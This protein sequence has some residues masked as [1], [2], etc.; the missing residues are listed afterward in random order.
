MPTEAI[1]VP[2]L[3]EEGAIG[4]FLVELASHAVGRRV[5]LLDSGSRDGTVAEAQCQARECGLDL[6]VVDCPPG[7]AE[8]ILFGVE[9]VPEQHVAVID[10]DGQH[11][12]AVLDALFQDLSDGVDVAVGSRLVAGASVARNWPRYRQMASTI[13]LNLVR[14]AVRCHQI[15][16]PLSGCFAL[17]RQAWQK[18]AKRF[19]TGGYK[20]LLDFLAASRDLRVTERPLQFRARHTGDSKLAFAVL[21]ELLVSVARGVFRATV[22]R[23]WI[24]FVGVGALGTASDILLTG[25]VYSLL[26]DAPFALACVASMLAYIGLAVPESTLA[27][28][29]ARAPGMLAGMVQNY[30]LNNKLTFGDRRRRG[31]RTLVRGWGLYAA[32][33]S[34]GSVVNW[35]MS[36]GTH[37][38]GVPWVAAVMLGVAT[39]AVVNFLF[40]AKLV[41]RKKRTHT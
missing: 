3:N 16:D 5:Y 13:F 8:A 2:V 39:G 33:Q 29:L 34:V 27:L 4:P 24:S 7:L 14:I 28:A 19:E 23:R 12:P 26:L 40:A 20:F 38:L 36:I 9:Q 30:L 11:E 6:A 22:P 37:A 17:R 18:V 1:L 35:S 31:L 41:W 15:R 25:I 32:S 10:G 21:W